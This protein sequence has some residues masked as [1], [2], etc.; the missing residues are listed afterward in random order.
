[1][2]WPSVRSKAY[3]SAERISE[4]RIDGSGR[5]CG[6]GKGKPEK[7]SGAFIGLLRGAMTGPFLEPATLE[8]SLSPRRSEAPF[9]RTGGKLN[10]VREYQISR[11]MPVSGSICTRRE[12]MAEG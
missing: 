4:T 12:P 2:G 1:M 11:K 3:E 10:L 7:R 5:A 9:S 6:S 8:A